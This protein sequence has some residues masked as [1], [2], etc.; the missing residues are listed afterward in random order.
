MEMLERQNMELV[1]RLRMEQDRL[2]EQDKSFK[3]KFEEVSSKH[4]HNLMKMGILL[5]NQKKVSNILENK[6]CCAKTWT[7]H[8]FLGSALPLYTAMFVS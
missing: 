5:A 1:H 3:T 2:E 6:P 4:S 7:E 8:S